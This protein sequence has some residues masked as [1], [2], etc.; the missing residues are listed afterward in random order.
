MEDNDQQEDDSDQEFAYCICGRVIDRDEKSC[1]R[2][3]CIENFQHISRNIEEFLDILDNQQDSIKAFNL[4]ESFKAEIQAGILVELEDDLFFD[5]VQRLGSEKVLKIF[6]IPSD[7]LRLKFL[8]FLEPK[9][10][11]E[12]EN[13][14]KNIKQN[15]D[16]EALLEYFLNLINIVLLVFQKR[17]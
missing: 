7:A 13:E 16:K 12:I 17:F 11:L 14:F 3:T 15:Q 1:G 10:A 2:Q 6:E 9:L 5:F 8:S 4:F